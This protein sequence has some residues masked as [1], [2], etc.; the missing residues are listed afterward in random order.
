M[1]FLWMNDSIFL[2]RK[3]KSTPGINFAFHI[4]I[5]LF[6]PLYSQAYFS[7]WCKFK[8]N[9]QSINSRCWYVCSKK[10]I[11]TKVPWLKKAFNG[12]FR[13]ALLLSLTFALLPLSLFF[14]FSIPFSFFS[15][16]TSHL[17]FNTKCISCIF[18]FYVSSHRCALLNLM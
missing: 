11:Q 13:H 2:L 16:L 18:R 5:R 6:I 9:F 14:S 4:F 8:V 1:L 10:L 12:N 7:F 17:S 15:L 3:R